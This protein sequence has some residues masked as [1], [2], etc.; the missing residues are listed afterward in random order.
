MTNLSFRLKSIRLSDRFNSLVRPVLRRAWALALLALLAMPGPTLAWWGDSDINPTSFGGSWATTGDC[1]TQWYVFSHFTSCAARGFN[2]TFNCGFSW[3]GR[4]FI[5]MDWVNGGA[6]ADSIL[7]MRYRNQSGGLVGTTTGW[8]D[9]THTCSWQVA[10]GDTE[11]GDMFNWNGIYR[12][13]D[14]DT[15]STCGSICGVAPSCSREIHMYGDK[16]VYLNDWIVFGG[17]GNTVGVSTVG[18]S[19]PFGESGVYVYGAIDTT[20]GNYF[21]NNLYGGKTPYRVSTGDCGAASL[22]NFLNFKGNAG[23]NGNNNCDSCDGYAFGYCNTGAGAGPMWGVGSDDGDRIWLNG[24]LIADNNTA[25]GQTWDQDRFLPAGMAGGWNRVLFKVHNGGGGFSGVVSLHAGNDFRAIEGSVNMQADRYGGYSVGY[26]QDAWFPTISVPNFAY[27]TSTPAVGAV[28]YTNNTTLTTSGTSAASTSP[29]P[30]VPY[31]RTM[32]YMWGYGLGGVDSNYA[33]VTGNP[34]TT[35]WTDTRTGVTG[36]RRFHFFAVSKSGRTSGQASGSSGSWTYDSGHAKYYDVYVDNVAPVNPSFSSVTAA[37]TTQITLGW[38]IPLDQGVGVANGSTEAAGNISNATDANNYYLRGDVGVQ[39]Y[40]NSSTTISN[41]ST[42]TGMND[43]GLTPN[44]QYTYTLEARD[45]TSQS[46]GVWNNATGQQG[47]TAKYTLSTP[48]AAG[49]VTADTSNPAVINWNTT[50]FGTG[51]GNVSSYRY[52]FDQTATHT[53]AGTEAVWSSGTITTVPTTG[54]TWYLHV[55][56]RNG[57]AAANG[58]LDTAVTAPTAPAV[59]THP[60]AQTNCSG[61]TVTFTAAASGTSPSFAWYKHSNAGWANAWTVGAS[62]GGT[63]LA[64]AANNNSGDPN[65]N[66]FSSTADINTAGGNS[67]GLFGVTGG[68]SISRGFPAAL[69]SGQIFQIDMDNG[70]VD[71]GKQNGFSLQNASGTLL[72]SFYFQ[73]GLS[74]YQFTDSTGNHDTGIGFYRR[75]VRVKVIVGTGSPASYSVLVA[76]CD[77]T[78]AAFS[79]TLATT[80]GPAKVVL[81]NNNASGGSAND[82][83]FNNMFAGS[84]YDNADNYSTFANG[85]DKGDQAIG[86]ATSSSYS[87]STGSNGDQY[88]ALAYNTAG[89]A[90]TTNATL[91]VHTI[92]GIPTDGTPAANSTTS[93]TWNWNSASGAFGYRVRDTGGT[94]KGSDVTAPTTTLT[95]STGISANTQYTRKISSF[96]DCG[97]SSGSTGQSKYSLQVAGTTPTFGSVTTTSIP[98]TTTGPVNLTSGS[99][100]VIFKRDG[101]TDLTLAQALTT[102]DT[103]LAANTQHSYTARGRNGDGADTAESASASKY[104]AQNPATTPTFGTVTPTTIPLVTTGPVNLTSGSSG[105]VFNRDGATDLTLV[106]GLT[107]TDTGLAANTQ[108]SYTAR[109]RNGDAADTAQSASAS[110]YS[111]QNA[112]TTPTVTASSTTQLDLSTTG[113]VNL[114]SG[115]S[116]VIFKRDGSTDLTKVSALTASDT[117][118][119]VNTSHSYTA[120]GVNGDGTASAASGSSTALYTLQNTATTPTFGSI[121]TTSID[122]VTTGPANL[123]AGSSGVIFKRDATTD[124]STVQTLS[125]TDSGLTANTSHSYT[126]RGLNG[127]AVQTAQSASATAWTLSVPPAGGSVTADNA[128]ICAG[129]S[130][131]WTAVGGFGAGKI[132]K[133]K[134]VFDQNSTHTFDE[135]ETDWSS[136]TIATTP[137]SSGTWYLHVK[138]YNGA[139]VGNGIFDY[140]VTVNGLPIA[141]NANG[142]GAFCSGGSGVTIGLDG[143][144]GGIDY[145]LKRGGTDVGSPVAGTGSAIS[146]GAQT[147][148]GTYSV[149]GS[150]TST[151][152]TAAM[153]G[154]ATVVDS[155]TGALKWVGGNGNWEFGTVADRWQDGAPNPATYC[156]GY[157]VLLDDSATVSSPTITLDTTVLPSSVTNSSGKNY[158]ISGSGKISGTAGLTKAG[159]GTLTLATPNDFTGD[160]TVSA[161]ALALSGSSSLATSPNI[162]VGPAGTLDVS[163]RSDGTLTL[164]SGQ[165]LKGRGTIVG[166][167]AVASGSTLAPG[168]SVGTLTN[169]GAVLLQGGGTNV[170]EVI[171]APNSAGVGYD[172]LSVTGDIGVQADSGNPF[173]VRLLSRDGAGAAGSVTNF[174]QDTS[175]NWTLASATGSVTNFSASAFSLD[176]S[177]FNN[178]L[179]GGQFLIEPGSINVRFTNN[180]APVALA[181]NYVRTKGLTLKIKIPDFMNNLTSDAD[182]HARMLQRF[183]SISGGMKSARGYTVTTNTTFLFYTNTVDNELDSINYVILDNAPYRVVDTKRYATNSITISVTGEST[184]TNNV[185]ITILG[186]GTNQLDF[187]G[188]PG[189]TYIAQYATNVGP[190]AL[191][192][193]LITTNAPSI[194]VWTFIDDQATNDARFYRCKWQAQ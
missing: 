74:N 94:Q 97:E 142:G 131:N 159:S 48:P 16:W 182:G 180:H 107:T 88:F 121:T 55:Q 14:E 10:L 38:T 45:N 150:N 162:V 12:N 166:V 105:V 124:L 169:T 65:C 173:T 64:S 167:V 192:F 79:G 168:T 181:T 2:E 152:C 56:G 43:T 102:T 140:S 69:T 77:G 50:H 157:N 164:A 21:A 60:L 33:D 36:H 160:T 13:A 155:L 62:G 95:E 194:G 134:Y 137:S 87:T 85:Q 104:T 156:D 135:S 109:G 116:G 53:F 184:S 17:Y 130:V 28:F 120:R 80:G 100:G 49:D 177:G 133:Y 8:N 75:G 57:D 99:S 70:N 114:S 110:A 52:V 15:G 26:E 172:T 5:H 98:L 82:L 147:V 145:Q 46:R 136:G 141:A 163:G 67:W 112:A 108:H 126:A 189:L 78:T 154:S 86:G 118:L 179:A 139:N 66:S 42:S 158:T 84:A 129:N 61:S 54:G 185:F 119:S 90:R 170:V 25:R 73:G 191:W 40:R 113:P 24:T 174:D 27:S 71:S 93:V 20:H 23:A 59:T 187:A 39:V 151:T 190:S 178:D 101:A 103:G 106:Q 18:W 81:F 9:C 188:V 117:G 44:T 47:S 122:L 193:D 165:T 72:M 128:T 11:T 83:Y 1:G 125:A 146:F 37:S 32:Q 41:W 96:D 138:G 153:S 30:G 123:T 115:S 111:G 143:S 35:S 68:E 144:Q 161:G 6:K 171:D 34:T 186:V 31:W 7:T 19:P 127:N 89:F 58:T 76:R 3:N 132:Q 29:S 175:Y 63:F 4:G 183:E 92:S 91:T 149:V 51:S 22:A 148:A 176:T